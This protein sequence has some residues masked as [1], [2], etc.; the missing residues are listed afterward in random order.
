MKNI[1]FLM[2]RAGHWSLAP[3]FDVIYSYNP[4][5]DWTAMHQMTLNGKRDGFTL[6][7]FRLCEKTA[8][9]KRGRAEAILAEVITAVKRWPE[10]AAQAEVDNAWSEQIGEH[11]RLEFP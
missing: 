3:A 9:M 6:E 8:M 4:S 7:D 1:T 2:D 10:Y 11:H 5:G